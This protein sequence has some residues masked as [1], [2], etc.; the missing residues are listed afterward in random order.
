M[1]FA[2]SN[3]STCHLCFSS[4]HRF[5]FRNVVCKQQAHSHVTISKL[6]SCDHIAR[7]GLAFGSTRT[8]GH[9]LWATEFSNRAITRYP[10]YTLIE[11]STGIT[12]DNLMENIR[13]LQEN[14]DNPNNVSMPTDS[15]GWLTS[16]TNYIEIFLSMSRFGESVSTLANAVCRAIL[17]DNHLSSAAAVGQIESVA[18]RYSTGRWQLSRAMYIPYTAF[19]R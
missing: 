11:F 3:G 1:Q 4:M 2:L 8:F 9:C 18:I 10:N 17:Y 16:L 5:V 6:E 12:E 15:M 19:T 14:F 13:T 7:C